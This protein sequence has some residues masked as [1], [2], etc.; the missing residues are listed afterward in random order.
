MKFISGMIKEIIQTVVVVFVDDADMIAEGADVIMNM[1]KILKTCNDS[2]SATGGKMKEE[3]CNFFPR[4][5]CGNKNKERCK[6]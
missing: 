2:H 3:K 6:R 4:C 1:Q 5:M